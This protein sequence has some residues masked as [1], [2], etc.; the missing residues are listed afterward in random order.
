MTD[1]EQHRER[2]VSVEC[3]RCG[4]EIEY[5]GTGRRP[6]FCSASCR[7]RAYSLRQ[8]AADLGRPDPMPARVREVV[9][10]EVVRERGAQLPR[11]AEEWLPLLEILTQQMRTRP[12]S[13][14]RSREELGEL[15]EAARELL[16]ALTGQPPAPPMTRQQ[17]RAQEREQRKR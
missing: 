16:A 7:T 12:L 15:T 14:A 13:L 17:R 8:A 9:E 5:A 1:D 3:A 4:D 6:K 11:T 10:R 2:L